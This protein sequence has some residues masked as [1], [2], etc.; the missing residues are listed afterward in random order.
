[1]HNIFVQFFQS[2]VSIC[3]IK[4]YIHEYPYTTYP[5]ELWSLS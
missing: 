2:A 1:V 4:I 3:F 5:T